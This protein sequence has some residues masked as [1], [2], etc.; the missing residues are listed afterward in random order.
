MNF[1]ICQQNYLM[2]II[3]MNSNLTHAYIHISIY[4]NDKR[5]MQGQVT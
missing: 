3:S 1:V 2:G 4:K 5:T